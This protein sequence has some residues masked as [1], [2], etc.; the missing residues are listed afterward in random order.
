MIPRHRPPFGVG[1]AI[2]SMFTSFGYGNAE[3]VEKEFSE[4]FEIDNVVLVPSARAGISWALKV[5]LAPGERVL[6]PVYTCQVVHE[7]VVRSGTSLYM[8][9]TQ[10]DSFLMDQ[11]TLCSDEFKKYAVILC[12]IYGHI[13]D[14]P[15]N[16]SCDDSTLRIVD[17]AM[18]VPSKKL[19]ARLI[20]NDV[21]ILSFGI[22]KCVYAGWGGMC[23]T[24]N[25]DIAKEIRRLRD[26]LITKATV[27]GTLKRAAQILMRTAAHNRLIYGYLRKQQE[28]RL[29]P[30]KPETRP[31]NYFEK[32]KDEGTLSQEWRMPSTT[33]DLKLI[34]HNIRNAER[35]SEKRIRLAEKYRENLRGFKHLVLPN[36]SSFP[37]SH[38]TVRV[39]PHLRSTLRNQLW[40]DGIDVGCLFHLPSYAAPCDYPSA[41][42]IASQV[43]N[44]P[45]TPSLSISEVNY[46]S[47]KLMSCIKHCA[48]RILF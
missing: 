7:A 11:A 37:L 5:S 16:K 46:I 4:A 9:D 27:Q 10:K 20:K 36:D 1:T 15:S 34:C 12:E 47:D 19:L 41:A 35:Y 48:S 33:P 13:Y 6:C 28:A 38:Y 30:K 26:S 23:F 44:L 32:W 14:L 43:I 39:A 8:L 45:L 42:A 25:G 2:A 17:M 22:G 18:T 24:R 29:Q 3:R 31:N 40:K 21:G